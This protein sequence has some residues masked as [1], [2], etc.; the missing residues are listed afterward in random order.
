MN[1]SFI[2]DPIGFAVKD[3]VL[4]AVSGRKEHD[5]ETAKRVLTEEYQIDAASVV[6]AMPIPAPASLKIIVLKADA[7]KP[8]STADKDGSSHFNNVR[9]ARKH[10]SDQLAKSGFGATFAKPSVTD[11]GKAQALANDK[12]ATPEKDPPK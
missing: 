9:D 6:A 4:Y 12:R 5:I 8:D 1:Q 11:I 3:G 2:T 7:G 10:A